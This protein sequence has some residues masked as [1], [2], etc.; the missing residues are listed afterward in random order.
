M[1]GAP[2]SAVVILRPSGATPQGGF[3]GP[4]PKGSG[5]F[6]PLAVLRHRPR[7]NGYATGTAPTQMTK[8]DLSAAV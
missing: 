4:T 5:L 6:W 3:S 8:T 2:R 1:V 7:S